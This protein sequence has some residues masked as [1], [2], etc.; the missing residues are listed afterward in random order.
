MKLN[1]RDPFTQASVGCLLVIA[2]WL[3]VSWVVVEIVTW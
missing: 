2:M 3:T 1:M